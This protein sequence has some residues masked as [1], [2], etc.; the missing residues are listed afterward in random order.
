M[1]KWLA[2][3]PVLLEVGCNA[4]G[5]LP[6]VVADARRDAATAP[7]DAAL[8]GADLAS[9]PRWCKGGGQPGSPRPMMGG[10][11]LHR[12]Q[13]VHAGPR[14]DMVKWSFSTGD[15]CYG[16]GPAIAADGTV[17]QGCSDGI[18]YA[19]EGAT[20]R[21]KWSFN[22]GADVRATPALDSDGTIYI[23]SDSGDFHALRPQDGSVVWS[24]HVGGKIASSAAVTA[25]GTI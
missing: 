15:R 11:P 19:L 2:F 16:M 5:A 17:Y 14:A 18:V 24:L 4:D 10:S 22:A 6:V 20:G 12:G 21:W 9:P 3:L 25:D 7:T 1:M 8:L 23:G 13:A